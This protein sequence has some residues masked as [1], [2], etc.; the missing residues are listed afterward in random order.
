MASRYT[1]ASLKLYT[2]S[3]IYNNMTRGKQAQKLA[4]CL[5]WKLTSHSSYSREGS[6]ADLIPAVIFPLAHNIRPLT[7]IR[8]A[9]KTRGSGAAIP[10]LIV[11]ACDGK[12]VWRPAALLAFHQSR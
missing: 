8:E 3:E 4:L 2:Q 11:P 9:P 10:K 6:G 5:P 1:N 12:M 7:L